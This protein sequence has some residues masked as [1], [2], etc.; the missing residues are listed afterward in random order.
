MYEGEDGNKF[1][2]PM[3]LPSSWVR[4]ILKQH[5]FFFSGGCGKDL[6]KEVSAFWALYKF[7]QPGHEVYKKDPGQLAFT[8][9]LL[10]H[11]DE[12]R[13]LK[14]SNYMVCM[15]ECILGSDPGKSTPGKKCRAGCGCRCAHHAALQ[16]FGDLGAGFTEGI[17][18][19]IDTAKQ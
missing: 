13:Y 1:E 10:V 19:A 14:K 4:T 16:R 11:G 12:G 2:L 6:Q 17:L 3:L 7:V 5:A 8:L 18:P 15:L 9:P